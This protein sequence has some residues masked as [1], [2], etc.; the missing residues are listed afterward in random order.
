MVDGLSPRAKA[1]LK[2]MPHYEMKKKAKELKVK[3]SDLLALSPARDPFYVGSESDL[4]KA[5]WVAEIYRQM[6]EPDEC[7]IRRMHYW[8]VGRADIRKPNG[9]LY[10]NT[11]R[12]WEWLLDAS[13]K[14][15]YL[16]LLPMEKIV[17]MR[18]PKPI[19]H[20]R[21]WP[22]EDPGEELKKIDVEKIA[23]LIAEQLYCYN[24]ANAQAYHLEVWE[25]KSTM[26]DRTDPVCE[27]FHAD[28]QAGLGELSITAVYKLVQRAVAAGKPVRIF[29]ISDFD[30]AGEGMPISVARK[31]EWFLRTSF[32]DKDIRLI[33]LVLTE[34]QC[35]QYELPRT[36][37]K[38]GERRGVSFE[39][40][41]GEGATE[42]DALEALHP[43]ELAR[44]LTEAM[45]PYFDEEADEAVQDANDAV[46]DEIRKA[47]MRQEAKLRRFLRQLDAKFED[48]E[49]RR[50]E[51]IEEMGEWLYD[52]K[53]SY[54]EQLARYKEAKRGRE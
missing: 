20:V 12:D 31:I 14:A 53:L 18:S 22:D 46:K 29:Y 37:I 47:V 23:E 54:G 15:R 25:E 49:L 1:L 41:H 35:I 9:E 3:V 19:I 6:G 11:D 32:P 44:L 30:P 39:E 13:A 40:R 50:A 42:L 17:D 16:G 8:I 51:L 10:L 24:P 27:R 36:P 38:E 48:P 52:S 21:Y 34:E 2:E 33:P 45:S 5:N 7:H 43:G 4:E 26:L 28:H